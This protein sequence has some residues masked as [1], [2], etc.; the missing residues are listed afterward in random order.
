MP[1]RRVTEIL[2]IARK[3]EGTEVA[4]EG[5]PGLMFVIG[6]PVRVVC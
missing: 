2:I 4:L 5:M 3:A 1:L 6:K